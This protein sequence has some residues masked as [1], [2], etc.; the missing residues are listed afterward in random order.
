M[1]KFAIEQYSHL[2]PTE[3]PAQL[4][5]ILD[6]LYGE[7]MYWGFYNTGE[8]LKKS[9][10]EFAVFVNQNLHEISKIKDKSNWD[11]K[12]KISNTL[13]KNRSG[14]S[15]LLKS[16]RK[17]D[18][19]LSLAEIFSFDKIADYLIEEEFDW[20]S[21]MYDLTTGGLTDKIIE[22]GVL[23]GITIEKNYYHLK[24][25]YSAIRLVLLNKPSALDEYS[26]GRLWKLLSDFRETELSYRKAILKNEV[27]NF[28][29]FS[30]VASKHFS[31]LDQ[32]KSD[33][34]SAYYSWAAGSILEREFF[35]RNKFGSFKKGEVISSLIWAIENQKY[36]DHLL[37]NKEVSTL[38]TNS[39]S[40]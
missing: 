21:L 24:K 39:I 14:H 9:V 27:I 29:Q 7:F 3:D 12:N 25:L 32:L 36:L 11:V 22:E 15:S 30:T 13:R 34:Y 37:G 23:T 4:E 40:L 33:L 16:V 17:F 31:S 38:L 19:N 2:L 5:Y 6:E 28:F 18:K 20:E 26:D 1:S 8:T 10:P 35:S